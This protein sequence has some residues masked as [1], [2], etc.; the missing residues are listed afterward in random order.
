MRDRLAGWLS[1]NNLGR[2]EVVDLGGRVAKFGENLGRVLADP[3][4]GAADDGLLVVELNRRGRYLQP[5][6]A[7]VVHQVAVRL[8]G[9]VGEDLLRSREEGEDATAFAKPGRD[10]VLG[11]PGDSLGER[12]GQ[13]RPGRL[14]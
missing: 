7:G 9:R 11:E 12:R 14:P 2:D 8:G 10:L 1:D 13:V 6:A 3:G 5:I 4:G